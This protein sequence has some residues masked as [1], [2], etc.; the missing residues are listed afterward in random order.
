ME[1][2]KTLASNQIKVD[3]AIDNNTTLKVNTNS[4]PYATFIISGTDSAVASAII[5][6]NP[7]PDGKYNNN[8]PNYRSGIFRN[9]GSFKKSPIL[10]A[11]KVVLTFVLFN[12][13][14]KIIIKL[15]Y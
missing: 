6:P 12:L 13:I 2:F 7:D 9:S 3:I 5:Y 15:G 10:S 1:S 11:T 4:A 8:D 14:E